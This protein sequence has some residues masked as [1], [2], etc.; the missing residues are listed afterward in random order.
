MLDGKE[1]ISIFYDYE[2]YDDQDQKDL[3]NPD[4]IAALDESE[5]DD[6]ADSEDIIDCVLSLLVE[7][8][9]GSGLDWEDR[10]KAIEDLERRGLD[11]R[12]S[13]LD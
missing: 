3:G 5:Y 8:Q 12:I 11:A 10:E 4:F 6:D 7:W 2:D 13:W 9:Y 1:M